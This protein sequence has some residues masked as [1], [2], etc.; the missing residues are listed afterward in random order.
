[1]LD[2][3]RAI[4]FSVD[5]TNEY[6]LY[7]IV[8]K[9]QDD[10]QSKRVEQSGQVE[11]SEQVVLSKEDERENKNNDDHESSPFAN[12]LISI[13][14]DEIANLIFND[15]KELEKSTICNYCIVYNIESEVVYKWLLDNQY[16]PNYIFL[17]GV[18]NYLGIGTNIDKEKAA[19]LYQKAANLGHSVAQYN[20]ACMYKEGKVIYRDNEK[21]FDLLKSS[22]EGEY[23][24]AINMLGECYHK[25]IGTDIDKEKALELYQKA[26]KLG[27][28]VAQ[29]NLAR[30]YRNGDGVDKDD[31]KAF[32]FATK[33]AEGKNLNGINLLGTF[34]SKG[35]GTGVDKKR[36]FELYKTAS[37]LGHK[38]AKNNLAIL[39]K[40]GEGTERN[41]D[42]ASELYKELYSEGY[43][44]AF[45]IVLDC[46]DEFDSEEKKD[47]IKETLGGKTTN[48]INTFIDGM[49]EEEKLKFH[50]FVA[51][52]GKPLNIINPVEIV[53]NYKT[54]EGIFK[55]V[56]SLFYKSADE[57]RKFK[58]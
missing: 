23:L 20:L 50:E 16:D 58:N 47:E 38:L 28:S 11:Q 57:I 41:Y 8:S 18:F 26:A 36:A 31:D 56:K 15:E 12:P 32:E 44:N 7:H 22:A 25:E 37:D 3:L 9:Q 13:I 53:E 2:Q 33:S 46:I 43:S 45:G 51:K 55:N 49:D 52:L 14:A 35:V 27:H 42:K 5:K 19:K 6:D 10:D 21:V 39:Y 29:Y 54:G 24:N 4:I 30:M 1:V 40:K 48:L 17:L 34:Y